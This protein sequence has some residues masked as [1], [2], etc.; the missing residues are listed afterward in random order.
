MTIDYYY[1]SG[2]P[3][4]NSVLLLNKTLGLKMNMKWL[5]FDK[6]EYK[7]PEFIKHTIPTIIDD[8]FVITESRAILGYLVEKYA[9]DD[10][11]YPKDLKKRT[12][13]NQRLYFDVG[14]LYQSFLDY[15][16]DVVYTGQYGGPT[17]FAKLEDAFQV[18]DKYLEGQAWI[19]GNNLSIAD[20]S[21]ASTTLNL[22]HCGFDVSKYNNVFKWFS[23]VKKTLPGYS[24]INP[25]HTVPTIYDNGFALGE[26]R[27]ILGYLVDQYGKDDF[28][29]PKDIKQRAIVNQR[30]FFEAGTLD[31]AFG[32]YLRG[33]GAK[34]HDAFEILDKYLEGKKWIAGD[35][36]TIADSSLISSVASIESAGFDVDNYSNVSNW[37]IRAQKSFP[38]YKST[39][40]A[41]LEY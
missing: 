28:L 11:L 24:Q 2:S 6:G 32:E 26:S 8:G 21:I 19:A 39:I 1:T 20:F 33:K 18:L 17:K 41:G 34:L 10:S 16:L 22:L 4:C 5:D 12:L 27:A 38:D 31:K 37:F 30:L 23:K 14:V 7:S 25:Q 9:K 35:S 3:P 36:K 15:Y 29:Y 40:G 13:I